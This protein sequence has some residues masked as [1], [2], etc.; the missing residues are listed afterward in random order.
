LV[1]PPGC[2]IY[3]HADSRLFVLGRLL[4]KGSKTDSIIF[5]GDRLD[6]NYFGNVGY[7]GEWGGIYFFE[8]SF[9]SELD[10]VVLRN[11]GNSARGT[12]P[13]TIQVTGNNASVG[14]RQ[15]TMTHTVIEN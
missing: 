5:Q 9:G 4:A 2:R 3:M 6:R 13:A 1:I 12:L 8:S 11:G 14:T 10:W 7:P 15:L